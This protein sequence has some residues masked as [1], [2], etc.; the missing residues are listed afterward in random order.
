MTVKDVYDVSQSVADF[1]KR[2]KA[3]T[4]R[5]L[6]YRTSHKI[7][8]DAGLSISELKTRYQMSISTSFEKEC[9]VC[10]KKFMTRPGTAKKKEKAT[11]STACSN[12]FFNGISRNKNITGY[13]AIAR[14]N[15]QLICCVCEEALIVEIHH[16]DE[17][18]ENN[19]PN[20]LIPLCPT[21]HQY[22][23]SRYKHLVID[24]IESFRLSKVSPA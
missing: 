4:G 5:K 2:Y 23:H 22:Y 21:H 7:I 13:R 19:S 14:R 17:N 24:K 18:K 15:F 8:M 6:N 11:C 10:K 1:I 9:P 12:T 20:N 3:A 16:Y